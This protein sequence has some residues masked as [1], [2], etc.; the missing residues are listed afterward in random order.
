MSNRIVDLHHTRINQ[1]EAE[2][3]ALAGALNKIALEAQEV[4]DRGG[5]R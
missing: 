2:A 5:I 1:I 4:L 3:A